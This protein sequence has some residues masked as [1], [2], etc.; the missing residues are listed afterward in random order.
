MRERHREADKSR[1]ALRR[2]RR[3]RSIARAFRVARQ[4][5]MDGDFARR[6]A[7]RAHD[8]L[9]VCS[10]WMCGNPRRYTGELTIQERRSPTMR[11]DF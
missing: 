11:E 1:R 10:C 5:D 4:L 2:H 9:A 6:W 3:L 8:H 7:L